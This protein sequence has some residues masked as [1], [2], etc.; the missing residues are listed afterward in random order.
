VCA[1]R[2]S[3]T[4]LEKW[5]EGNGQGGRPAT[6]APHAKKQNVKSVKSNDEM[7]NS[8]FGMRNGG[9]VAQAA[10]ERVCP[11]VDSLAPLG[12]TWDK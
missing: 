7:R 12:E 10:A 1:R 5:P 4:P 9:E 11:A 2:D 3:L 6:T 8:E